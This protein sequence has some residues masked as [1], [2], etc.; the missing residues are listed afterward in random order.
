MRPLKTL[1][2]IIDRFV[3]HANPIEEAQFLG[4][5]GEL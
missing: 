1:K 4:K 2:H 5:L 3:E